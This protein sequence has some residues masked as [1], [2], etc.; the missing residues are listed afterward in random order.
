VFTHEIAARKAVNERFVR[1]LIHLT[2]LSP[3]IVQAMAEGR[4]R[5]AFK[6]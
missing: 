4:Q 6:L 1:R 2:F 3:A 5:A